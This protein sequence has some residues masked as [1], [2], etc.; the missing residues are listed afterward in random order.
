MKVRCFSVKPLKAEKVRRALIEKGALL[1]EFPVMNEKDRVIFPVHGDAELSLLE[2]T[3]ANVQITEREMTPRKVRPRSYKELL[4][5][6]DALMPLLPSSFDI[7]GEIAIVKLPAELVP[8]RFE[9]GEGLRQFNRN[10]RSVAL[11]RGVKGDLRI[12]DLEVISGDGNLETTHVENNLRFRLDPSLVYFSP[13]LATERM[14]VAEMVEEEKVLDMFAGVGPFSI[15]IGSLGKA[16]SIVGID[17]NPHSI[18]YFNN[19]ILLNSLE[20]R[21]ET[22]LGDARDISAVLGPFDRIIMNLPHNSMDFLDV[23]LSS[24][25][26]GYIHL[27]RVLE[28]DLIMDEVRNMMSISNGLNRRMEITMM[29]DVHNYSPTRSMFVFDI[30]VHP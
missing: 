12:M 11:N 1:H 14:R 6:D 30:R 4:E 3:G 22:H 13:R 15:T 10:L 7:I 5:L 26:S 17:L 20:D 16:E 24:M 9:I 29:R 21:V 8:H 27:Y 19:N 18:R 25:D 2:G 28:N 23:A